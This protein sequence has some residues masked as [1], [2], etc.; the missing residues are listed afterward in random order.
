MQ[1]PK[2]CSDPIE[3]RTLIGRITS[4]LP[5]TIPVTILLTFKNVLN[6]YRFVLNFLDLISIFGAAHLENLALLQKKA[7]I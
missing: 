5:N 2:S 3:D 1:Y 4:Y 6:A 7:I